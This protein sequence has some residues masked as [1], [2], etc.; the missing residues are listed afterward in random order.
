MIMQNN[1]PDNWLKRMLYFV[2]INMDITTFLKSVTTAQTHQTNTPWSCWRL[3]SC[4]PGSGSLQFQKCRAVQQSPGDRPCSG[5][6]CWGG[7]AARMHGTWT[8]I[9]MASFPSP[10]HSPV[11]KH[12]QKT[13]TQNTRI[14]ENYWRFW[15]SLTIRLSKKFKV[16]WQNGYI[17]G[18]ISMKNLH[19]R[20][21]LF[22]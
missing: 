15:M 10:L 9:L 16:I 11:V 21:T 7:W 4:S 18:I 17:M 5:R 2:H 1:K 14:Y 12:T 22:K 8:S 6:C 20:I 19:T 13:Y 3:R